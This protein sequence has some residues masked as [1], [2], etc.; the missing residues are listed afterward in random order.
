M[1]NFEKIKALLK[2]ED[3]GL[4]L[5]FLQGYMGKAFVDNEDDPTSVQIVVGDF[6]FFGGAVN[7]ELIKNAKAPI[8]T[9]QNKEWQ[10]AIEETLGDKVSKKYRY[11]I[12]KDINSFDRN[13]LSEFVNLLDKEYELKQIDQLLYERVLKESWSKDLCSQF[14][15]YDDF[16]EKG[17]GFV[18]THKSKVVSGASSYVIYDNGLEIEIDTKVD[19]RGKHLATACGAKL[20]L[21][22]LDRNIYPSWDAVDLRSVALA[23][24]LG[25]KVD[26]PYL[27]Y[28]YDF[29]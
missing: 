17:L 8:L 6:S 5:S 16:K 23:E 26:T 13:K 3:D 4:I 19:Y 11:K 28:C 10:K 25:Y 15:D 7:L 18:I 12:K 9:P 20:I 1:I 22:C 21:E 27:V 29:D 2:A 14:K 24:K